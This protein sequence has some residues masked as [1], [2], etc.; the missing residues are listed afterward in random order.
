MV[1]EDAAFLVHDANTIQ[2]LAV[3]PYWT[4]SHLHMDISSPIQPATS[5]AE[6]KMR[7]IS[8]DQSACG[9]FL[10]TSLW[11]NRMKDSQISIA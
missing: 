9:A 2:A 5:G 10:R 1:C 11:Y 4:T 3:R 8:Y 6:L 7:R